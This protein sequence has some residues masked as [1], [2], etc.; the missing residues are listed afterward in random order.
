MGSS[1][2]CIL[3]WGG[4]L[5]C[6]VHLNASNFGFLNIRTH[7]CKNLH[8]LQDLQ[9]T[10][11]RIFWLFQLKTST[12]IWA[13]CVDHM[14]IFF[15]EG[16]W[17]NFCIMVNIFTCRCPNRSRVGAFDH[18]DQSEQVPN[19]HYIPD[20]SEKTFTHDISMIRHQKTLIFGVYRF[21]WA[22]L[23]TITFTKGN[24]M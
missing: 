10:K 4:H 12:L 5:M 14:G 22:I 8:R 9:V 2:D 1:K 17:G 24:L 11:N 21:S 19:Q 3:F 13:T 16:K 15:R 23:L 6:K 7:P 20:V 18:P